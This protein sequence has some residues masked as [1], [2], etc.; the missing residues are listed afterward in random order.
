MA[1]KIVQM[2]ELVSKNPDVYDDIVPT[3]AQNAVSAVTQPITDR[4]TN[5]ATTQ[6]VHNMR[7]KIYTSADG[8]SFSKDGDTQSWLPIFA[9]DE[10]KVGDLIEVEFN[11]FSGA[12]GGNIHPEIQRVRVLDF[13]DSIYYNSNIPAGS[14]GFFLN[15]YLSYDTNNYELIMLISVSGVYFKFAQINR[16]LQYPPLKIYNIYK[17]ED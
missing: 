16:A 9:T 4:S 8:I 7:K 11:A 14:V 3:L 15:S 1:K 10:L 2:K 12:S 5:I 6:F 17:I 13:Y